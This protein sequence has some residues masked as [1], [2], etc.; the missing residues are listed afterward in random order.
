MSSSVYQEGDEPEMSYEDFL[1]KLQLNNE[2]ACCPL[3]E[4]YDDK[5]FVL[6]QMHKAIQ[7]ED[8]EKMQDILKNVRD[9]TIRRD[10][11]GSS[12]LQ[13][14]CSIKSVSIEL[15]QLLLE[16]DPVLVNVADYNKFTPLHQAV[17]N[18]RLDLV[19]F[20]VRNGALVNSPTMVNETTLHFAC[21]R[22]NLSMIQY[23][24]LDGGADTKARNNYGSNPLGKLCAKYFDDMENKLECVK[25]LLR[26]TYDEDPKRKGFYAISDIIE[27][28][29]LNLFSPRRKPELDC[30]DEVTSCFIEQFYNDKYNSKYPLIQKLT[31]PMWKICLFLH[32]DIKDVNKF[33]RYGLRNILTYTSELNQIVY[34]YLF[35][36]LN[37]DE[38]SL[39]VTC[40]ILT[41]I[42]S[43]KL[44]QYLAHDLFANL[45]FEQYF[46]RPKPNLIK[47]IRHLIM[48]K[49]PLDFNSIY[50]KIVRRLTLTKSIQSLESLNSF[51]L[52]FCTF[53]DIDVPE[54]LIP[55]GTVARKLKE[56]C[57]VVIRKE[58]FEKNPETKNFLNAVMSL[59]QIPFTLRL[60]LRFIEDGYALWGKY[61][62]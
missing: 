59:E 15:V 7:N 32:D 30:I 61:Y 18:H 41:E 36:N 49:E 44:R 5:D 39:T 47:F 9:I 17:W 25:F 2:C 43:I 62:C 3:L 34:S 52:P 29:L 37:F 35:V 23:L 22:G 11:E 50:A 28:A 45:L 31:G 42:F 54:G 24:V 48:L 40:D 19:C 38:D 8:L 60:Y 55:A 57:R 56:Y 20:L 51:I 46:H 4:K 26:H 33:M 16:A 10:Y 21:A 14:A 53:K 13:Y 27:P 6:H 58:I 12:I 1:R